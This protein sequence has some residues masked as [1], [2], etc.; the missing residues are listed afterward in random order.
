[1]ARRL[2]FP[3][4]LVA[5]LAGCGHMPVSTMWALRSFD[6]TTVDPAQLRA[7][8]RIPD[9]LEPQP[10]GV[11]LNIGWRRDGGEPHEAKF[12]LKETTEAADLAPLAGE[13]R[14]GT[15]IHAFRVDSA[16]IPKIKALQA[17]AIEEKARGGGKS[18]GSFGVGAEACR[19]GE[20][21]DGPVLMTTFLRTQAGDPYLTVLKNVDLR[22][23]VTKEK[24]FDA[25]VPMCGA[26]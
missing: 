2:L 10:G 11:T 16:D 26:R 9:T 21:A 14:P 20:L 17:Q 22:T 3:S 18:H 15:R 25:L 7:A 4:L 12:I 19:R 1:M 24:N 6:A 8:I 5:A 13:K 23:L